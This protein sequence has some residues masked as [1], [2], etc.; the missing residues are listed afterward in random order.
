[1]I[2]CDIDGCIFDNR[3]RVHLIPANR[4]HTPSWDAFNKACEHDSPIMPIIN[5][6]KHQAKLADGDLHRKITFVTSR[7]EN[8]RVETAKQ[9]ANYFIAYNCKL[10]MRDMDDY[11]STVDYK[12]EKFS[13]LSATITGQSLII[14]DHPGIIKM[15]G[16]NFPFAQRLLVPSFD[17]TVIGNANEGAAA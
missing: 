10:I 16:I 6:V 7:G 17:C 12:R 5:L 3:H 14:D 13:E 1:M 9:L 15:V 4:M 8:A 11:R 2:I